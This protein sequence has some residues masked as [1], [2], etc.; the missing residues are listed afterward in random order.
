MCLIVVNWRPG[1]E[2]PL[3]VVANRDEFRE[4]PTEPMH[5]W[6]PENSGTGKA[7]LAGRDLRAGGTW[8]ALDETGRIALLTNIRPGY[9]GTTGERSRGELPLQYLRQNQSIPDFHQ[10]LLPELHKYGGF[11]M[12]LSDG[13]QLFWFSTDCPEG[14]W[15]EAGIHSISNDAL[16]TPWPK[17][18]KAQRQMHEHATMME[19]NFHHASI[20][21][22]RETAPDDALPS[23][24]VPRDWE[25]LLSAQTI[26]GETYGTRSRTWI[27]RHQSGHIDVA[28]QQLD[29]R[30]QKTETNTFS[31]DANPT[32]ESSH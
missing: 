5:W 14:Q 8:L 12:I 21:T 19:R 24:G 20:L 26:T 6:A 7:I 4:R 11:N 28:E 22:D 13:D 16:N 30:G 3:L 18:V 31:L 2:W 32:L 25:R 15:L 27:R 1:H 23:T 17:T 29:D 9:I 10:G